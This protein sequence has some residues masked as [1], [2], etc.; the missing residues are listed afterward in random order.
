MTVVLVLSLTCW[1]IFGK[2]LSFLLF[3]CLYAT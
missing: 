2:S 1:V 3:L